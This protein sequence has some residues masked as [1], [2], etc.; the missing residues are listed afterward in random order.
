MDRVT[1]DRLRWHCRRGLL[2]L[3]IVLE[4]FLKRYATELGEEELAALA[5]LLDYPDNDLWEVVNGKS[6]RY[7]PR[8][9]SIVAR[10]RTA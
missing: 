4:R 3:D 10:L 1:L 7:A 8:H 2:E 6:E 5:E 9:G